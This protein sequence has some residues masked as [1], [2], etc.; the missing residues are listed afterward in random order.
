MKT[1][2][3]KIKLSLRSGTSWYCWVNL[4]FSTS[5][6]LG[7]HKYCSNKCIGLDPKVIKK[8]EESNIKKYGTKHASLNKDIQKKVRKI[9]DSRTKDDYDDIN[10]KRIDTVKEK[11]GVGHVSKLEGFQEKRKKSFKKI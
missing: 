10:K 8:K 3:V 1:H 6:K 11:Y 5:S 4:D 7:Y 2:S 9:Y